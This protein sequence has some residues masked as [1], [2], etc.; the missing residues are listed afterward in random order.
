MISTE[1]KHRAT[2]LIL[3]VVFTLT[4]LVSPMNMRGAEAGCTSSC[5]T[6]NTETV[7]ME[8]TIMDAKHSP[9]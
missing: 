9:R 3:A 2:N 6:G 4:I 5:S 1:R 8:T 7:I